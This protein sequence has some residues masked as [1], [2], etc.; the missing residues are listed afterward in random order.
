MTVRVYGI[1]A[2]QGSKRHIGRGVMIESS[3]KVKPWREAVK[4]AI[5]C[6]PT[7]KLIPG[8]V[9][10]SVTFYL[11]RPKCA[12]KGAEA[13]K[14][15]DLDKLLRSTLDAITDTGYIEDDS[16]VVCITASKEYAGDD[17]PGALIELWSV[18]SVKGVKHGE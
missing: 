6:V 5:L 10:M 14:K 15:P 18:A 12:R 1:P 11:P 8:A 7:A 13:C 4:W 2:P 17:G 3:K 9:C 16:R